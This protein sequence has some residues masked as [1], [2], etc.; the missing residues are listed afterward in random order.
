M[1]T[2]ASS[3][4]VREVV[5]TGRGVLLPRQQ[6]VRSALSEWV[7]G[8]LMPARISDFKPDEYIDNPK[9][10]RAMQR[11][12]QLAAAAAVIAMREARLASAQSLT[13]AG[14]DAAR[15]GT[16][17]AMAEISPLSPDL[18]DVIR[19]TASDGTLQL[20]RFAEAALHRLHPFR[21]L[22]LLV[23][24]A[25]A[26]VSLLFGLQG[27]S[28][29]F[30]SGV[31]AG[32]QALAE[33]YWI[34]A[35]GRADLMVC[36]AADSPE[37]AENPETVLESAGALVLEEREAALQRGA[38]IFAE[39]KPPKAA[40]VGKP[41][42]PVPDQSLPLRR[43]QAAWGILLA[44]A[45]CFALTNAAPLPITV[46]PSALAETDNELEP[47]FAQPMNRAGVRQ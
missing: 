40:T 36:E 47:A 15:A 43:P 11:T 21:R 9:V 22:S 1:T 38:R 17:V 27:P 10:L 4:G 28:F 24:M 33:A 34:I 26:H 32:S 35:E 39:L 7:A 45:Q 42:G 31:R 18:L 44:L 20:S 25:A 2:I 30:N 5:V 29:T 13:R 23:N 16:A 41:V 6:G 46:I 8:A 3:R 14:I 12:F 37:L 19:E